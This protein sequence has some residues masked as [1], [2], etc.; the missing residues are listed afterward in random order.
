MEDVFAEGEPSAQ[1]LTELV[2]YCRENEVTTI[3]AEEMASAE[4]SQTLASEVGADVE[5]IYTAESA[6]DDL[7]YLERMADNLSKIYDSLAK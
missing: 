4:V 7:T 1:Q 5:T 3:F 2:N 6:E